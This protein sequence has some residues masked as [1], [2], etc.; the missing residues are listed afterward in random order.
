[1]EWQQYMARPNL[2]SIRHSLPPGAPCLEIF[3][4]AYGDR[5]L[6]HRDWLSVVHLVEKDATGLV[7][8]RLRSASR[9][10]VCHGFVPLL[11]HHDY[12]ESFCLRTRFSLRPLVN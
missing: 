5:N 1:V 4:A 12:F 2:P 6:H 9:D 11:S 7:G 10:R 8:L 3:L